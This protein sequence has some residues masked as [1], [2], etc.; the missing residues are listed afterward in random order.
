MVTAAV[1]YVLGFGA[2]IALYLLGY[3]LEATVVLVALVF[4]VAH[5]VATPQCPAHRRV[6]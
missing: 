5:V 1:L 2:V 6:R 4:E 3:E